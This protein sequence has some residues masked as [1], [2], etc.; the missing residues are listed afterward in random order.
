MKGRENANNNSNCITVHIAKVTNKNLFS[1]SIVIDVKGYAFN[2][3]DINSNS[4]IVKY[5]NTIF[6]PVFVFMAKKP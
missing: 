5:I 1:I 3:Y 6:A 4:L 2:H